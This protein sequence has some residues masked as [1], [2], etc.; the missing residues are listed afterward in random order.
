[1]PTL[2]R[3]RARVD[4]RA[5]RLGGG[6]VAGDHLNF[7]GELLG[8]AHGLG[9]ALGMAMSGVDHHQVH[10]GIDQRGGPLEA[11]IAH[12]RGCGDAQPAELVLAGGRVQHGLF[13]VLEGQQAGELAVLVGDE[14][15]L[16]PARL[17]EV[18][19]LVAVRGLGQDGEIVLRH[20]RVH[21]GLVRRREAHV[22]VGDDADDAALLVHHRKTGEPVALGQRTR[23]AE[24]LVR[25]QRHRVVDDAALEPLHAADL[26][27][28]LLGVE[29]AVDHADAAGLRHRDRH[30]GF[31]HGVHGRGQQRDVERD[32]FRDTGTGVGSRRQH[33]AFCGNKQDVVEGQRL[34]NLHGDGPFG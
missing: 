34:A 12:G 20:H 31:G 13:G 23:I 6:D 8:T 33:A 9:H 26:P 18:L 15:L 14:E 32:G 16:D 27:G 21:G 3:V 19:R 4:Q 10:P 24:R 30:R 1:M 5:R 17:H 28:L 25:R 2:I 29:V 7:V 11:G 22:A